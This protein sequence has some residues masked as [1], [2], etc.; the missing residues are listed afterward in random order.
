M[1]VQILLFKNTPVLKQVYTAM[2]IL[3]AKNLT[4]AYLSQTG[5]T[6]HEYGKIPGKIRCLSLKYRNNVGGYML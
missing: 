6:L 3:N 2:S 5:K 4:T 1:C